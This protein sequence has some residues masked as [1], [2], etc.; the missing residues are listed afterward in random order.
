MDVVEAI[1]ARYSVRA[2]KPDPVP[3]EVLTELIVRKS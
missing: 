1:K 3:K 2:Y